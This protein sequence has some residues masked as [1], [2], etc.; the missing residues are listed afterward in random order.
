MENLNLSFD[1]WVMVADGL[2]AKLRQ[3]T[4][5]EKQRKLAELLEKIDT[6]LEKV[7]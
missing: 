5:R 2:H 6:E 3:E 4:N 7:A 1:E